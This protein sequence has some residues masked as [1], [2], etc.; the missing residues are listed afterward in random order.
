MSS[1][2][3]P[4]QPVPLKRLEEPKSVD[5][6]VRNLDQIIE[7]SIEAN[8]NIGYFAAIYKRAT[9]SIRDAINEGKFENNARMEQFDLVFAGRYFSALNGYF[10]PDAYQGLTHPWEVAF[11]GHADNRASM[12][13]QMLTGLNAHICYDLGLA[14]VTVAPNDLKSLET[15]FNHINALLAGQVRGM[16]DVVQTLSPAVRWLRFA[17]PGPGEIWLIRWL[18][19]RFRESAWLFAI[20]LAFNPDRAQEK[21]VNQS[22]WA[23]AVGAWYLQPPGKTLIPLLIRFLSERDNSDVAGN[24]RELAK[25]SNNPQ[26]N[27]KHYL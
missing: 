23:A 15:D 8:S 19:I 1:S 25:A 7:W 5:D 3:P 6:V 13:Q 18:L 11:V 24:V 17:I 12:I 10:H 20:Y 21:R 27:V 26:K 4:A 22:A 14:A 9:L 16:L 2:K